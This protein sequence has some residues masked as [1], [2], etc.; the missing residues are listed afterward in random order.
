MDVRIQKFETLYRLPPKA[1]AERRRLDQVRTSVL[2]TAFALTVDRAGI[3]EESELCIRKL[4]VPVSLRLSDSDESI[5]KTWG[6]ALA[7]EI[8]RAMRDGETTN[9]VIYHSR[10]QALLDLT[11]SVARSDLRRAWAWRQLGLWHAGDIATE[12]EAVAELTRALRSTPAMVVPMLNALLRTGWLH[13][14]SG[15]LSGRQW[16][17]L[18]RA[19]LSETGVTKLLYETTVGVPSS[20]A[21]RDAWRV[22]KSSL[23]LPAIGTFVG[24]SVA[25]RRAVAA[26]AV[27]EDDPSLLLNETAQAVVSIIAA[28]IT[29]G[30]DFIPGEQSANAGTVRTKS[31]DQTASLSSASTGHNATSS[32]QPE[33]SELPSRAPNH[34]SSDSALQPTQRSAKLPGRSAAKIRRTT[35]QREVETGLDSV[36]QQIREE[37]ELPDL[38]RRAFTRV[39]GLLFLIAVMEDLKLP[40][41]IMAHGMLGRRP[42][43]WVI[44]QLALALV[45]IDAKDPAAMAFAGLSP[46][47][48]PPSEG[49]AAPSE[50][51]A[52]ALKTLAAQ[53]VTRLRL[54]FEREDQSEGSLVDFVVRRRGEILADPGWIEL[55]LSLDDVAT[56]VRRAGLDLNPGY[57]PWLGVVM[58]FV[59]E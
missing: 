22:T 29:S 2:D 42:F 41:Q 7:A 23:L 51:E 31:V 5:A 8:A 45:P 11:L 33:A 14:I 17:A 1:L 20:R 36:G 18:A 9:I 43:V 26:L 19:A 16:E 10:R 30:P 52:S 21:F 58:V 35:D 37:T 56:E 59:Y 32:S 54:L 46:D 13:S 50:D 24:A 25:T 53:I 4:F 39:A 48:K 6:A 55:R 40:E 3:R 38:R 12:S 34:E 15:R 44:H 57:V 49:E 28:A 47:A 27:M